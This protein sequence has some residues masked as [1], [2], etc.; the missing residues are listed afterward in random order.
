MSNDTNGA[1]LKENPCQSDIQI[2]RMKP[3][4]RIAIRCIKRLSHCIDDRRS[5][6][7]YEDESVS[8]LKELLPGYERTD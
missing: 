3:T 8:S 1:A 7:L 2:L 6:R 5:I 4:I